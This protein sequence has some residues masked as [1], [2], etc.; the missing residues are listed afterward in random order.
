M[1]FLSEELL[2]EICG[3][4]VQKKKLY[5]FQ[6]TELLLCEICAKQLNADEMTDA[7]KVLLR[8]DS[9]QTTGTRTI[10]RKLQKQPE[11]LEYEYVRGFGSL[12]RN[13]RIRMGLE[14]EELARILGISQS[15]LLRIEQ[16]RVKPTLNLAHRIERVLNIKI[17]RKVSSELA[18]TSDTSGDE[19]K[20]F[21]LGDIL[22]IEKPRKKIKK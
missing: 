2:C 8:R 18:H 5:I 13:A 16:E 12:I 14:M 21:T 7:S 17:L 19:P 10:M 15:Y 6:D 9:T 11:E 22:V 3:R 1:S 4:P 20:P